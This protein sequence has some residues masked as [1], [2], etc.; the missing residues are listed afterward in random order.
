MKE[1]SKTLALASITLDF[2]CP[3]KWELTALVNEVV[4]W[5]NTPQLSTSS[6]VGTLS[7]PLFLNL[8]EFS[9]EDTTRIN[10]QRMIFAQSLAYTQPTAP[11]RHPLGVS[12]LQQI[13][14]LA[15]HDVLNFLDGKLK[16]DSLKA[17]TKEGLQAVF[18]LI[19]GS[20]LAVGYTEPVVDKTDVNYNKVSSSMIVMML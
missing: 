20:I 18:L 7:S 9:I 4:E 8:V 2:V 1:K 13:S 5:L 3:I 14:A 10:F 19:F 17:C 6:M 11:D 16:P 12:E 15:G